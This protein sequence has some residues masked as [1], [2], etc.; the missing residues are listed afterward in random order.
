MTNDEQVNMTR[1]FVALLMLKPECVCAT[2]NAILE[3]Q[4]SGFELR[5]LRQ[6]IQKKYEEARKP[7]PKE[8]VCQPPHSSASSSAHW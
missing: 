7:L 1:E 2:L 8:A 6:D 4:N 5:I 3:R